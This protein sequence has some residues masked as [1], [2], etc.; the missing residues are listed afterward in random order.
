M[1]RI[2][3]V[4]GVD[5]TKK[6]ICEALELD[7]LVYEEQYYLEEDTCLEYHCKNPFIYFMALNEEGKVIGYINFSPIC[8]EIYQKLQTGEV[9]DTVV[10]AQDLCVY[11]SGQRLYGY[12]SS[13]VVHPAYRRQGIATERSRRVLQ[14]LEQLACEQ[15]ILFYSILAD[16][17][18]ETGEH[19]LCRIG[20]R[21]KVNSMHHSKIM[22]FEP[23]SAQCTKTEWN[24]TLIECYKQRSEKYG[25]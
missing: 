16:A 3:Y 2:S 21:K 18:S 23:L 20:F 7:R 6:Q 15:D 22:I 4:Y 10:R 5:V 1:D 19:L 12:F 13:I 11:L 25:L 24:G 8:E 14:F 9:I 17:V